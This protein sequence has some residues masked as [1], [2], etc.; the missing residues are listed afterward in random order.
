MSATIPRKI[1][2]YKK[3]KELRKESAAKVRRIR[4]ALNLTQVEFAARLSRMAMA[5][6]SANLTS[7]Y[8]VKAW[9]GAHREPDPVRM[10]LID[11]LDRQTRGEDGGTVSEPDPAGP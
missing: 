2:V 10:K 11:E 9:E 1:K 7:I 8:A 4:E 6:H 5:R 3:P